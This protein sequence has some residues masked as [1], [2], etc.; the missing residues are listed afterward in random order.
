MLCECCDCIFLRSTNEGQTLVAR[1]LY[2][3]AAGNSDELSISVGDELVS[4]IH[5][6]TCTVMT[7]LEEAVEHKPYN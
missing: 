1:A 3:F 2:D 5:V 4:T 6:C 7:N